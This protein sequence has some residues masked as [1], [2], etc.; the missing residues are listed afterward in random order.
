ML[1]FALDY[2]HEL[3]VRHIVELSAPHS[4]LG[5]HRYFLHFRLLQTKHPGNLHPTRNNTA[6]LSRLFCKV[7]AVQHFGDYAILIDAYS[8]LQLRLFDGQSG[9][10]VSP[11]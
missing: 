5:T 6:C 7:D 1:T 3:F 11:C 4:A 2:S 8:T 9:L 10:N